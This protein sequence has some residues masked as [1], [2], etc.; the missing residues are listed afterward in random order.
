MT[1]AKSEYVQKNYFLSLPRDSTNCLQLFFVT[2]VADLTTQLLSAY[3]GTVVGGRRGVEIGPAGGGHRFW[4]QGG[5]E[6]WASG[7]GK[8]GDRAKKFMKKGP[9]KELFW[10]QENFAIFKAILCNF[11]SIFRKIPKKFFREGRGGTK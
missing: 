1:S 11:R 5:E 3:L 7:G 10:G 8:G 9:K 2:S 4:L 6:L